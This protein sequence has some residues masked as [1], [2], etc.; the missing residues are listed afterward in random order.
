VSENLEKVCSVCTKSLPATTEYFGADKTRRDGLHPQCKACR[1]MKRGQTAGKLVAPSREQ[2]PDDAAFEKAME[3]YR[4]ELDKAQAERILADSESKLSKRLVA[5]KA[6]DETLAR[7]QKLQPVVITQ[8]GS[9]EA[10]PVAPSTEK[11][12][13]S[14]HK[15]GSEEYVLEMRALQKKIVSL[16]DYLGREEQ[17]KREDPESYA[18]ELI[19]REEEDAARRRRYAEE[20]SGQP[21]TTVVGKPLTVAPKTS[22]AVKAEVVPA[23]VPPPDHS[24]VFVLDDD[25]SV[26]PDLSE[27]K[28]PLPLGITFVRAPYPP[29]YLPGSHKISPGWVYDRINFCWWHV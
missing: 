18:A 4:L 23:Y 20:C 1:K 27:A 5:R 14:E 16:G 10:C 6:L 24:V 8:P 21:R 28:P 19:L 25:F 12:F 11:A 29:D 13:Q 3:W 17:W 26:F 22:V 7:M 15:P 2:F 9:T